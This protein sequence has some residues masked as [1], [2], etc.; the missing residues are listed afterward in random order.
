MFDANV[1]SYVDSECLPSSGCVSSMC[2]GRLR[3]GDPDAAEEGPGQRQPERRGDPDATGAAA[4]SASVR[5][6]I[7]VERDKVVTRLVESFKSASKVNCNLRFESDRLR[8]PPPGRGAWAT[9][10]LRLAA[11]EQLA[12]DRGRA[13]ER[14]RKGPQQHGGP[15]AARDIEDARMAEDKVRRLG[16]AHSDPG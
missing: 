4:A 13:L 1:D 12:S 10:C 8:A 3:G 16:T 6:G 5:A 14:L 2:A 9:L 7:D 15:A 11:S